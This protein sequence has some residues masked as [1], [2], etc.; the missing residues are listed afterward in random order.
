MPTVTQFQ[1]K[2]HCICC[3][4]KVTEEAPKVPCTKY[5]FYLQPG[6]FY[7]ISCKVGRDPQRS[8]ASN[9][10][11]V[12]RPPLKHTHKSRDVMI[13]QLQVICLS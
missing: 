8:S 10:H 2:K 4:I 1:H 6:F 11:P 5:T 9:C 13:N 3:I 12:L 7:S